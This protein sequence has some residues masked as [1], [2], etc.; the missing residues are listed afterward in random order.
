M[1]KGLKVNYRITNYMLP[2]QYVMKLWKVETDLPPLHVNLVFSSYNLHENTAIQE[3]IQI[4]TRVSAIIYLCV[5][6]LACNK[7]DNNNNDNNNDYNDINNNDNNND[8]INYNN[9]TTTTTITKTSTII[10]LTIITT[11]T[12][13]MMITTTT[14][15]IRTK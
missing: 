14:T 1:T 4:F 7:N 10:T 6:L 8:K 15:T 2:T 12:I 9:T 11:M 5:H 13:M 3:S